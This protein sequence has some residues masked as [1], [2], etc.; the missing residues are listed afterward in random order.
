MRTVIWEQNQVWVI[1]QRKLPLTLEYKKCEDYRQVALAIKDMLVRGAPAIGATAAYGMA[2]AAARFCNLERPGFLQKMEEVS[3]EF[4]ATRPTAVNLFW[5][6]R[7]IGQVI[8]YNRD[9]QPGEISKA[10]LQ[11][12]EKIVGDDI[13]TNRAI[14]RHGNGLI[15][16]TANILTHCNTG[17]LA[18]VEFGTALGVIRTA[19]G[20]GKKVHVFV[21][22]TRPRLQG[23]RL[24]AWELVQEN[25]P[26]TLIPDNAA[27][28]LMKDG[29]VDLVL[30]G[31][32]RIALNGDTAN[33]IGTYNVA[34]LAHEN[35]VPFY[36]VAPTTTI[37]FDM[38]SGRD[39]TIE[40]RTGEEVTHIDGVQIAPQGISVYN[41][42]FDVTPAR[43]IT[44][45]ITEKGVIQGPFGDKLRSLGGKDMREVKP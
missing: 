12:A 45:I 5:A 10:I 35:N 44:A 9:K 24:T 38:E 37:D 19:H 39:I 15:P 16:P 31:A 1:D 34:V 23:A 29:R 25:I 41:P 8:E 6:L 14:G 22:E 43:Y 27:G 4:A 40:E 20:Q 33:K 17:S 36:V 28:M 30:V 13:D 3:K 32:D 2:L 11:T 26:A 7:E 42:A 18:T 21:D